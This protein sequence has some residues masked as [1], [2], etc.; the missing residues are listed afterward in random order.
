MLTE[1]KQFGKK[2]KNDFGRDPPPLPKYALIFMEWI[3]YVI[4]E[5]MSFEVFSP[6][7]SLVNENE[8]K[9][10]KIKNAKFKK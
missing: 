5:E 8:I 9:S 4:S 2:S 7:S 1:T 6:I 3:C 10:Q